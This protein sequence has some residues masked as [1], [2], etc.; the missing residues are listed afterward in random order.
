MRWVSRLT[1]IAIVVALVAGLALCV[2]AKIPDPSKGGGFQTWAKFRDGSRL[3]VGSPVVI[4]GVRIGDISRL[5]IEGRFARIDMRLQDDVEIP[6]DSFI[7][8]RADSLF[9][10]S[11]LEIIIT[12]GEEG[13]PPA[14]RLRSGEPIV[15]VIEG[16]ST[17]TVLRAMAN[18]MPKID[19]T[20]GLVHDHVMNG[21]RFVA[22]P[23][24]ERMAEADA[25]LAAG[26]IERPLRTSQQAMV[27]LEELSTRGADAMAGAAGDVDR[28]LRRIDDGIAGARAGMADA[29]TD[30]VSALQNTRAGLD[31]VDEPLAQAT[32]VMAAIDDGEGEDFRG[33]LGRMVN[34]PELADTLEDATAAGREAVAG[35]FRFKSWLGARMELNVFS[36]IPRIYATAEIWARTDK[37]YLVEFEKGGLGGLPTDAVTDAAGTATYT[38]TQEIRDTLRFTAQLGKQ[39]G[40]FALRGGVKDSTFGLGAD[41]LMMDGRLKLSADVF[42]G[43]SRTPRLKFAAALAVFRSLYVVAGVDD[44]LNSPGY[45]HINTGYDQDVPDQFTTVRYGRDY[46]VGGS[47]H[48]TDADL[49]TLLRVYGAL[50]AGALVF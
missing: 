1:T 26:T 28:T 44:V 23:G 43:F 9:G 22:G 15:R 25:W 17:D 47:L 33:T 29:R 30:L 35:F 3:A 41:A 2:R 11:Y 32:E 39:L 12:G 10:D 31:Q 7:T 50:L 16:S 34:D 37:F 24:L 8:K 42:G 40:P 19:S 21:R 13:A 46:F 4:A 45:L 27:R 6:T 14:R 38:R 48:F 18:A 20:L 5:S 36:R 49:A